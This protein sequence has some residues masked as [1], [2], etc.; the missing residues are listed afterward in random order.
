M[1]DEINTCRDFLKSFCCQYAELNDPHEETFNLHILLHYADS[2]IKCGPLW[3]SSSML[4]EGANNFLKRSIHGRRNV[5]KELA[6]TSKVYYA[7]D[8]LRQMMNHDPGLNKLKKL[9]YFSGENLLDL[10]REVCNFITQLD[11]CY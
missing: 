8:I 3:A 11:G 10:D 7:L 4:F 1:E 5:A 2:V 9:A 6:N